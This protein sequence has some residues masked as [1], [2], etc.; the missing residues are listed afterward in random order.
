[1]SVI[2][3]NRRFFFQAAVLGTT[4][5]IDEFCFTGFTSQQ[6][7]CEVMMLLWTGGS[8]THLGQ[9]AEQKDYISFCPKPVPGES[10]AKERET[11]TTNVRLSVSVF[12]NQ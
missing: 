9:E 12:I 7:S 10:D 8:N 2:T 6:A 1:L 3:P 5:R 4:E 11:R